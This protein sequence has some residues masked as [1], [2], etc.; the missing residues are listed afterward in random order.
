MRSPSPQRLRRL[1]EELAE[2]GLD[3]DGSGP[4]HSLA[5]V[6]ID[7]ALRPSVHE[8][9]V[10]SYGAILCPSVDH[11][12]WEERTEL[13][14]ALR[15]VGDT[16]VAAA[17]RYADGQSSWLVLHH[18][19]DEAWAV[20]DRPAGSERDLVVL[21]EALDAVIVQRHPN[22]AVRVVG[23]F[24]VL[25]WNGLTWHHEKLVSAWFD[26]V[27]A[28]K[29]FADG[30]L[31]ETLLE[32]AVHDL[33]ARGI[34]A[35]L[36]HQPD[37]QLESSF[38]HRLP[39]PPALQISRAADL[40]PLRHALAQVDGA[41]LFDSE[42]TLCAIGV[43]LIPSAH[44]EMTI[45]PFRGT[46]HTSA[47]RYSA[48]DPGAT[49][50]VISE[51]GPVTVMRAGHLLGASSLAAPDSSIDLRPTEDPLDDLSPEPA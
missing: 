35:T 25:R 8:R 16:D 44:A 45:A 7:Y 38:E 4:W 10:P 12:A 2:V 22:G 20:F 11:A 50:I 26:L 47:R 14:V 34:G 21:A 42:G 19:S 40:A 29:P 49:V 30:K 17:R 6:E 37:L 36:V 9:R 48:D 24:G 43:R 18:D 13:R 31:L 5:I 51:D 46:R 28:C 1:R 39:P 23:S 33:G 15:P 32:F 41:S 27:S 3:L